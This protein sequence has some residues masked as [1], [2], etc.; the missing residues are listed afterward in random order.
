V[1]HPTGARVVEGL[2]PE[3][4]SHILTP[5]V[6][7]AENGWTAADK[8]RPSFREVFLGILGL[9]ATVEQLLEMCDAPVA[10]RLLSCRRAV[11]GFVLLDR[12]VFWYQHE[13]FA[14]FAVVQ[15]NVPA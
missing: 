6:Q 1:L 15:R 12:V 11:T 13:L 10:D 14:Q 5:N 3:W 2:R 8:D 9:L 4:P 7:L